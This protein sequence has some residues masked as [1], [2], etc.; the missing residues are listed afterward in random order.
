MLKIVLAL[1]LFFANMSSAQVVFWTFVPTERIEVVERCMRVNRCELP[2]SRSE[3]L[4]IINMAFNP[5]EG[6]TVSLAFHDNGSLLIQISNNEGEMLIVD[7]KKTG[8]ANFVSVVLKSGRQ[9][10]PE[11][12]S[13]EWVDGQVKYQLAIL[14][15]QKYA[16]KHEAERK[17]MRRR[18][19]IWHGLVET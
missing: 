2:T 9:F 12:G 8:M 11:F 16:D 6:V 17:E 18:F 13:L 3:E 14:D 15:A 19:N 4:S 1:V 10:N 5:R 7:N